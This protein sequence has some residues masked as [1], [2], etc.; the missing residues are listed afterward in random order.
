MRG[1][2]KPVELADLLDPGRIHALT[3]PVGVVAGGHFT[4]SSP[5]PELLHQL[6]HGPPRHELHYRKGDE[7]DA[8]QG[9]HHEQNA[10]DDVGEHDRTY[11]F[12][13]SGFRHQVLTT[14]LLA[15]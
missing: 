2:I 8:E 11:G 14:Q 4:G 12:S 7:Q 5:A 10:F 3:P 6:L 1:L 13:V 15:L 9:R